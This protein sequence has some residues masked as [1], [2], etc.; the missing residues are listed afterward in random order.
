MKQKQ[1]RKMRLKR[2]TIANLSNIDLAKAQGGVSATISMECCGPIHNPR[3]DDQRPI[4]IP[5]IDI[6][7]INDSC[8]SWCKDKC[9]DF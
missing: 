2:E 6:P 8:F 7:T 9:N 5:G 3:P 4:D 1:L